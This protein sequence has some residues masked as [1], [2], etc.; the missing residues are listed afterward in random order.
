VPAVPSREQAAAL[1]AD[2][3]LAALRDEVVINDPHLIYLDGNSL[4]RLPKATVTR[5]HEAVTAEWGDGLIRSWDHWIDLPQRVG[6]ALGLHLL[7]AA[8]GQVVV[9]D[10]TS[11]NLYKLVM[12]ALGARPDRRVIVSDDDNFPTD[13][14]VLQGVPADLRLVHS[15][16]DNGLDLAALDSAIDRNTALVTLSH[17]AYRSGA[18]ADMDA[19]TELAHERG[20]LVLWD[21]SH[22]VGAVPIELDRTGADL[23]VGCSYKYLNAGPGAPAFLYVRRD[24]QTGLRQPIWGWFGQRDQ[25]VMDRRYEPRHDIGRF[26]V[27]SP[28]ILSLYAVEEGVRLLAR[29][30]VPALR[31]KGQGLTDRDAPP[32]RGSHVCLEHPDAYGIARTLVEQAAVVPDYRTPNRLRLGPAPLYTRYVDVWDGMDR[33]RG[34]VAS[35]EYRSL[36]PTPAAVT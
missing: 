33:L 27:G 8:P 5:L 11:V 31:R 12:A 30:G 24:L 17:V 6:D 36:D 34:L 15:D 35:G 4:G 10:S 14:Y 28:P 3:P 9:A 26:L 18:L 23:A 16:I 13:L 22:A 29:A 20:A 21:L 2:D 19:V 32:R 25:F 7:G 1:D